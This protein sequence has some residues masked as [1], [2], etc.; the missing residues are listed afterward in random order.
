[1]R[2]SLQL[3]G[4]CLMCFTSRSCRYVS[5]TCDVWCRTLE[6]NYGI[7]THNSRSVTAVN[8]YFVDALRTTRHAIVH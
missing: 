5:M 3:S 1:M 7:N 8:E 4:N 6:L 2:Y